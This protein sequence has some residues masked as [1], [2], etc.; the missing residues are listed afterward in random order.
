[1]RPTRRSVLRSVAASGLAVGLAGCSSDDG[2]EGTGTNETMGEGTTE[3]GTGMDGTTTGTGEGGEA[4]SV[5]VASFDAGEA[6]V[7]KNGMTLYMFDNDTKGE[8]SSACTGGCAENWP[9]LTVEG[10]V[11]AS[12]DVTA[13]LGTFE[14]ED[15]SMQ[16]TAN[17]WPL[18]YYAGDSKKGDTKGQGVNDVWWMVSPAGKPIRGDAGTDDGTATGTATES[19]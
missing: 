15:G 4:A 13:E 6:L 11:T 17:G 7:A 16:V 8:E 12:G 2:A 18:Y 14:R 5:R 1:M 10:E 19:S 9:P 3:S